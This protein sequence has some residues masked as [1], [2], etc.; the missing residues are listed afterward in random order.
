MRSLKSS[1]FLISEE[2]IILSRYNWSTFNSRVDNEEFSIREKKKSI[3]GGKLNLS[4][5]I[6]IRVANVVADHDDLLTQ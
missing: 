2:K 6:H 1:L 4:A 5:E 3:S